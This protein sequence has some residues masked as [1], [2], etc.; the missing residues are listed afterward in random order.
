MQTQ[1]KKSA[2]GK[3]KG[4]DLRRNDMMAHL[5]DALDAGQDIGHYGRLV[6]AMVAHHFLDEEALVNWLTK[7][8]EFSEAQARALA[9]QVKG[10]D[11]NPPKPAKIRQFQEQ[12]DFTI[13]PNVDDPDG[14]NVYKNLQFPDG[15]YERIQEY[16]EQKAE[17][18]QEG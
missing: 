18:K 9:L 7:N 16:Y 2:A 17:A 5:M 11:Y 1:Q 14:C 13:C 4:A 8:P 15:V 6:F 12:Q 3:D 10:R